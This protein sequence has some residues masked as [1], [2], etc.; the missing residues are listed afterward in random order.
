M[1]LSTEK[2]LR[3]EV[4]KLRELGADGAMAGGLSDKNLWGLWFVLKAN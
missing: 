4:E 1:G 2:R 3:I